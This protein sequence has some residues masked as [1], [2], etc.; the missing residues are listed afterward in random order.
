MSLHSADSPLL[1]SESP[2]VDPLSL[3][4]APDPLPDG[5]GM[6]ARQAPRRV[7]LV[8]IEDDADLSFVFQAI[9]EQEGFEVMT[10]A[11]GETGVAAT[12]RTLPAAV[13][14]D[15]GLPRMDGIAVARHLDGV[16]ETRDIPRIALTGR[17]QDRIGET[18]E[19]F[20]SVLLK[21]VSRD[22]LLAAV[23]SATDA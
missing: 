15:L 9:L 17:V 22:E 20:R 2:T 11:S 8:L 6:L 18:A 1:R 16:Q 3:Q 21:P 13:L 12:I 5:D 14:T 10:A 4:T 7:R 23:R 19:L